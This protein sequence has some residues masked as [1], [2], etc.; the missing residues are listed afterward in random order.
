MKN[1][2]M[3]VTASDMNK[4]N[5]EINKTI[6]KNIEVLVTA[7]DMNKHG[8]RQGIGLLEFID[9][10]CWVAVAQCVAQVVAP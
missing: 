7:I 2:E 4:Q 5:H 6:M 8:N 10:H 3:L 9:D 1:E